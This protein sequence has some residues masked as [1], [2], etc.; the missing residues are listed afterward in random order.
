M[1]IR[2]VARLI[3]CLTLQKANLNT[4][5]N[6][7]G[8]TAADITRVTEH[9]GIVSGLVAHCETYD[10][11]K[12]TAFGVKDVVI[13]GPEGVSVTE[14]PTT[15]AYVHPAGTEAGI[16][17]ITNSHNRIFEEGPGYN[18]EIG[19]ALGIVVPSPSAPIPGDIQPTLT[20]EAAQNGGYAFAFIIGNRGK[21][22][23]WR[24]YTAAVGSTNWT[25]AESG[26]GKAGEVVATPTTPGQPMQIQVRVLLYK[27]DEPYGQYSAIQLVTVNP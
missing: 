8:A 12:K 9:L 13:Y 10:A 5:L 17:P 18:D 3:E 20:L 27:N 6:E 11:N 4:Y 25:Q 24:L 2:T 19:T 7:V 21:S 23:F 15:A 16:M 22:D 14:I 26:T 1:A